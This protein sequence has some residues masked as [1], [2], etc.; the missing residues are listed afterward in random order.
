MGIPGML[1]SWVVSSFANLP[2]SLFDPKYQGPILAIFVLV[3]LYSIVSSVKRLKKNIALVSSELSAIRSDLTKI[4]WSLDR[5]EARSATAKE[6]EAIRKLIFR[7]DNK[8][9]ERER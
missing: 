9:P 2:A 4:Q 8:S 5:L 7:I 3:V 1:V 6:E